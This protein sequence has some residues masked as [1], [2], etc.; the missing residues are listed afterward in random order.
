MKTIKFHSDLIFPVF[1]D[2]G[3]LFKWV[4][5][6]YFLFKNNNVTLIKE[7]ELVDKEVQYPDTIQEILSLKNAIELIFNRILISQKKP[8]DYKLFEIL[9]NIINEI[10]KTNE[11]LNYEK[12]KI[13]FEDIS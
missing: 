9:K 2:N 4:D 5:S 3:L 10:E 6:E 8:E 12:L 1:Y 13:R 7:K 11:K